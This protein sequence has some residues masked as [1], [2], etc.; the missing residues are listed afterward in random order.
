MNDIE[1]IDVLSGNV[2]IT[3]DGAYFVMVQGGDV[4]VLNE[5][6]IPELVGEVAG[7]VPG[8]FCQKVYIGWGLMIYYGTNKHKSNREVY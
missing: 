6:D 2:I 1:I 7:E 5:D 4:I 3:N 8:K